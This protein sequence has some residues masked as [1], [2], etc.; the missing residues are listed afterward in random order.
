MTGFLISGSRG[1]I[2]PGR[3][4]DVSNTWPKPGQKKAS[5]NE[6][7]VNLEGGSDE[8]KVSSRI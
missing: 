6:E 4:A 5:K 1:I 7:P 8:K 3:V 2:W